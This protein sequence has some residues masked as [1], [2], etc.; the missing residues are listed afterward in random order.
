MDDAKPVEPVSGNVLPR[1][2]GIATFMRLPIARDPAELDIALVGVPWD[3]GTTNRAG[4]AARPA[5]D[6]QP[7]DADAPGAPCQPASRPTSCAGSP[8]SATPRSIPI[9]LVDT[10]ERIEALLRQRACRR[11]RA[12]VGRRRPPDHAADPA[13]ASRSERPVGMVHFDA[14]SDTS[15]RYFGDDEL[16]ARHAVP[17]RDRGRPARPEAHR[18]RSASAARSTTADDM[19]WARG[20]G[21]PHRRTSRNSS[22]SARSA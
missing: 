3:G 17:P 8:I 12:A 19:D 1:F 4:R 15:D 22:S 9:D 18:S 16:H 20:A 13:R 6:P 5:R 10:L 7:V 21:H 14:H 11:R 2:A